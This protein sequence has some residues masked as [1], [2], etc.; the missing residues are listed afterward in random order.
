MEKTTSAEHVKWTKLKYATNR[1][2][3]IFLSGEETKFA[4]KAWNII[5]KFE[6]AN[7]SN[8]EEEII[9]KMRFITLADIYLDYC[10]IAHQEDHDS[11]YYD[12]L[13]LL[14]VDPDKIEVVYQI[15]L[16]KVND[17]II[18]DIPSKIEYLSHYFRPE[19]VKCLKEGFGSTNGF[20]IQLWKSTHTIMKVSNYEIFNDVIIEKMQLFFLIENGCSL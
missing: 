16:R 20:F 7:Y 11:E 6:L 12:W 13:A 3:S 15:I 17:N 18:M 4:H 9:V 2:L 19:I 10:R 5:I 8:P 14:N 1:I